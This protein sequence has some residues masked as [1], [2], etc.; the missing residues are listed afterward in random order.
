MILNH[1]PQFLALVQV[2]RVH[3]QQP[4]IHFDRFVLS[5]PALRDG[6]KLGCRPFIGIDG[7][8]VK[9]PFKGI[10]LSAVTLD[11]NNDIQPFTVC[12]CE[13]ESSSTWT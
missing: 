1:M 2:Y 12:V 5:F 6:F 4:T 11:G 7:C 8:Y 10:L 9:G 13:T 3:N